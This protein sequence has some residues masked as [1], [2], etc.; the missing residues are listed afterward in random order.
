ML[1]VSFYDPDPDGFPRA[2]EV[3]PRHRVYVDEFALGGGVWMIGTFGNPATEGSMCIFRSRDV[4]ERFM[5]GDPFVLEGVVTPSAI[6]EWDP[7][8]FP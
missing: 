2:A 8:V 6:R 4:A 7:L 3:Y 5:A 1:Y